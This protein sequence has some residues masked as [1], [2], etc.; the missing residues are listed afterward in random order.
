MFICVAQEPPNFCRTL[1]I[2]GWTP[3]HGR[4]MTPS[5]SFE[6]AEERPSVLRGTG[7]RRGYP[8]F[9]KELLCSNQ[10]SNSNNSNS[11]SSGW[12]AGYKATGLERLKVLFLSCG[13]V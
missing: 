1:I 3:I 2:S 5:R 9:D 12:L 6:S 7:V 10:P 13:R 11:S 4:R 8:N